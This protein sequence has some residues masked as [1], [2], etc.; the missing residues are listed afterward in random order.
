MA[1]VTLFRASTNPW[2]IPRRSA[3][4]AAIVAAWVLPTVVW[5]AARA[6]QD[7]GGT[8]VPGVA[9]A[10]TLAVFL[11]LSAPAIRARYR[12]GS[13]GFRLVALALAPVVPA[14]AFYPTVFAVA[15][16]AKSDLVETRYAPQALNQR[17]TV[18][19]LLEESLRE[20]DALPGLVA[21]VSAGRP[22][23][24]VGRGQRSLVPGVAGHRA[25]ALPGYVLG[26]AVWARRA[27][28]EPLRLQPSR[29]PQ[30]RLAVRRSRLQ[31]DSG[32]GSSAVLRRRAPRLPRRARAV[33]PAR[34][35][36]LDCRAR[37][38]RLREP[39]VHRRAH[40]LRGAAAAQRRGA[41]ARCA[42]R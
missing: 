20:I 12:N 11:T 35:G 2:L 21:L 31:L 19:A 28:A 13:Q 33:R 42:R 30:P 17:A 26:G 14:L 9:L 1:V 34:H 38:A 27:P 39:A 16:Q 37:D 15:W 10:L 32:R 18:Y 36:R 29:G 22:P 8:P 4:Q 5:S 41:R 25:G 23:D 7:P 24:R 6:G 3:A 40:S